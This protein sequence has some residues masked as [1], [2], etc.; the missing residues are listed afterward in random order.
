MTPGA[1]S[2]EISHP[3]ARIGTGSIPPG[4]RAKKFQGAGCRDQDPSEGVA[5]G[6]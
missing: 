5:C 3:W 1:A 4:D 6:L 2:I